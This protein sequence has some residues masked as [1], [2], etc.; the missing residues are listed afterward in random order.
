[1]RADGRRQN[2]EGRV[3]YLLAALMGLSLVAAPAALS[4]QSETYVIVHGAWGGSWPFAPLDSALTSQGHRV[5]RTSLTG[6]GDRVHLARPDIDLTTHVNDI[7]NLIL[8]ENLRDVILYG[9]SY[10]GMVITGVAERI[11]DRIKTLLYVDALV[12]NDGESL[13]TAFRAASKSFGADNLVAGAKDGFI[14]PTWVRPDQPLPKDVPQ[15]VRTFTETVTV[16]NP[17]AKRI[18]G[19]YILTVDPGK[20]EDDFSP[21]AERARSR[22]WKVFT[23]SADHLPERTALKELVTILGQLR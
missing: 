23:M 21:F 12:P 16:K 8:F 4:A 6:L 14:V 17:A 11:P 19:V 9:H 10:G 13:V 18:P 2:A 5:Y 20:T 15:P 22:G 7:V 3:L 1:M